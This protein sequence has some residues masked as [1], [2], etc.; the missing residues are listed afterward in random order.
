VGL[1]NVAAQSRAVLEP[2]F[3]ANF[4]LVL[5]IAV[6]FA[7]A[8]FFLFLFYVCSRCA[9]FWLGLTRLRLKGL[10]PCLGD[11]PHYSLGSCGSCVLLRYMALAYGLF[12]DARNSLG[13]LAF[14]LCIF[15]SFFIFLSGRITLALFLNTLLLGQSLKTPGLSFKLAD[16][17]IAYAVG[18]HAQIRIRLDLETKIF[19]A[20]LLGNFSVLE[21][22]F[23]L[24]NAI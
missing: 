19:T 18:D 23:Q 13:G 17:A 5:I 20:A 22:L 15:K 12:R 2:L 3:V 14:F 11:L 4:A 7:L 8:T 1:G 16:I 24:C 9:G 21:R 10:A 6:V